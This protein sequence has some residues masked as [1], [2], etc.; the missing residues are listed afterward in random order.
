MQE[1]SYHEFSSK[2]HNYECP[3]NPVVLQE[4]GIQVILESEC[5][6]VLISQ[7]KVDGGIFKCLS[8]FQVKADCGWSGDR[9]AVGLFYTE[10]SSL[11]HSILIP[12]GMQVL[13]I[14]ISIAIVSSTKFNR[15]AN[16]KCRK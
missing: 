3:R 5:S 9:H 12:L 14:V 8:E 4:N 11:L 13:F 16:K 15:A 1:M 6:I 2:R 10:P 7:F